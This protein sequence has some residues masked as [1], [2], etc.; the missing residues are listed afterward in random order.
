MLKPNTK[1]AFLLSYLILR[2]KNIQ[3]FCLFHSDF[4]WKEGVYKIQI[5]GKRSAKFD[6]QNC[7]Q[8]A[9][10]IA[11]LLSFSKD[12]Y[13]L[14]RIRFSSETKIIFANLKSIPNFIGVV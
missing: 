7:G 14:S 8:I 12:F 2:H 11:D 6:A 5:V 3:I 10:N 4:Y 13:K 1:K 9:P